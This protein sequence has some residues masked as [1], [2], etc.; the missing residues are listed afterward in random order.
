MSGAI[1]NALGM[2]FAIITTLGIG[3]FA[4]CMLA[5]AFGGWRAGNRR[6]QG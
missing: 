6:K 2:W 1:K 3:V 4:F 5:M